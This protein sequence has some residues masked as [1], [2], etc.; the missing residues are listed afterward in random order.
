MHVEAT[1]PAPWQTVPTQLSY[2]KYLPTKITTT[3]DTTKKLTGKS[4]QPLRRLVFYIEG[5]VHKRQA[6]AG[7]VHNQSQ[8]CQLGSFRMRETFVFFNICNA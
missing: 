1:I 5:S 2:N 4:I 8:C 7:I 3:A 6:G